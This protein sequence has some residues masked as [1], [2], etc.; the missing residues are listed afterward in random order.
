M[1]AGNVLKI[2]TIWRCK[3]VSPT[4][5]TVASLVFPNAAPKPPAITATN[6]AINSAAGIPQAAV[7]LP[8]AGSTRKRQRL[9]RW[10]AIGALDKRQRAHSLTRGGLPPAGE[11]YIGEHLDEAEASFQV[12]CVPC[13]GRRA[14]VIGKRAHAAAAPPLTT[15][16]CMGAARWEAA[17]CV[18]CVGQCAASHLLGALARAQCAASHLLGALACS[19][20]PTSWVP[21][22]AHFG[23][24]PVRPC[25]SRP[26][27]TS[28]DQTVPC[29]W[30]CLRQRLLL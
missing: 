11:P 25:P 13:A 5:L 10:C 16:L 14:A 24:R 7:Q 30:Q 27:R 9:G 21:S 29:A 23:D 3:A 8:L 18:T 19:I 22:H 20:P 17:H 2:A 26:D 4:R 6:P 15:S 12:A 28:L 1:E